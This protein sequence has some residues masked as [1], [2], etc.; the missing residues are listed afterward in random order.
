MPSIGLVANMYQECNALPGWIETHLPFFDE[1]KVLHS[2]PGG[3]YSDDGTLEILKKWNIPVEFCSIDDGFGV[4]RTR[5]LQMSTC[6]WTMLLDADERFYS[7]LPL[8]TCGGE[9]TPHS[10]VDA[11]LQTYDFRDLKTMIPNWENIARLGANLK[12]EVGPAYNQGELLRTI[13]KEQ[14]SLDAI[15]T[16]RRH[17]HD[18]SF[19]RPT[20]NWYTDPDWQMRLVKNHP[21]IYFDPAKRMHEQLV[22]T[23]NTYRATTFGGPYFDHFHFTM[24]KMEQEQRAHDVE[25]YNSIHHGRKPPTQQEYKDR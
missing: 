4:V 25:I 3:T 21:S 9:S 15:I 18:F 5:A 20:Q 6:S 16:V 19:K 13:L 22:G 14:P 10:E 7:L 23:N 8:L 2:G 24:K 1:I 12:V 17:W 11:I